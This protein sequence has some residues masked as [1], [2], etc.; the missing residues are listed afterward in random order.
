M[1][2]Y[3]NFTYF[4]RER[5]KLEGVE[6]GTNVEIRIPSISYADNRVMNI[7]SGRHTE[8]INVD[9]LPG[10]GTFVSSSIKYARITNLS[11]DNVDLQVSGST[12]NQ[13]YLLAP[14]GSFMFSSE[15]VN[16]D[17]NNFEYGDLRSIKA[18][19]IGAGADGFSSTLSY[20][21]ALT[22]EE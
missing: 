8:V 11:N 20:F 22:T 4:I 3:A 2:K 13:H 17:F 15:Y 18:R 7:P 9:N 21:I 16:E 12:S 10:A 1:P 19:S 5:V 6:R 14:S